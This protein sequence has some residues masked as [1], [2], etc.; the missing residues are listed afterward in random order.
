MNADNNQDKPCGKVE[1][2]SSTRQRIVEVHLGGRVIRT[3]ADHP[4]H[5]PGKGWV[6]GTDLLGAM[7]EGEDAAVF[8]PNPSEQ[9]N[10]EQ[11]RPSNPITGFVAGTP[12]RTWDGSVPIEQLQ[13]GDLIQMPPDD[14]E[15]DHEEEVRDDD[16]TGE[17]AR[18]WEWN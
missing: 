14:C 4:F 2:V 17:D 18:W 6:S 10:T 16:H 9:P 15:D 12:I 7:S 8:T 11:P 13:P 3:T 1:A 5:V